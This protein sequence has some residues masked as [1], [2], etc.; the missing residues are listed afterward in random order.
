MENEKLK[1][2]FLLNNTTLQMSQTEVIK[3]KLTLP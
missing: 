3:V 2:G 1:C